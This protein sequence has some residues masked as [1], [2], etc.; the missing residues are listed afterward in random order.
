[1]LRKVRNS[2]S[3]TGEFARLTALHLFPVT[4]SIPVAVNTGAKRQN[5]ALF[6]DV[7]KKRTEQTIVHQTN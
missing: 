6:R 5:S 3:N 1:M 7:K 2:R 4:G